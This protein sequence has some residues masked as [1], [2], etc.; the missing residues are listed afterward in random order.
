MTQYTDRDALVVFTH[1]SSNM[2]GWQSDNSQIFSDPVTPASIEECPVWGRWLVGADRIDGSGGPFSWEPTTPLQN[3]QL[4]GVAPPYGI[5]RRYW[6]RFYSPAAKASAVQ[7]PKAVYFINAAFSSMRC[8]Q[9]AGEL[10]PATSMYPGSENQVVVTLVYKIIAEDYWTEGLQALE[11]DS[12]I[13]NIYVDGFYWCADET[14]MQDPVGGTATVLTAYSV[15][16]GVSDLIAGMEYYIGLEQG[17][18]PFVGVKPPT[19]YVANNGVSDD[20][21]VQINTVRAQ[22]DRFLEITNNP[23]SFI[24][25]NDF[26]LKSGEPNPAHYTSDSFLKMGEALYKARQPLGPAALKVRPTRTA[27]VPMTA[28]E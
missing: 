3:F 22:Y 6:E 24:D 2:A 21:L 14:A 5:A 25:G 27:V 4:D 9:D 13:D 20:P 28:N 26:A 10:S 19:Q 1:G 15:A 8:T 16:A 7:A 12:S 18:M 11:N 17:T 23:A